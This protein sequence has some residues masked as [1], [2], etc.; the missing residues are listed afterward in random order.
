MA[1]YVT[2]KKLHR[3]TFLRGASALIA[4][5]YLDA[6]LP[7]IAESAPK[8]PI[9]SAFIY[10]PNGKKMDEWTP[11]S[12][13]A[14]FKFPHLLE[15]LSRY[16]EYIQILSGLTLDGARAHGDGA[17]DHARSAG[18]F[19]T[20]AHPVKTDVF[21]GVSIDQ[22]I[23]KKLGHSTNFPSLE[24]GCERGRRSGNCDSGYNCAYT[25]NIAWRSAT[26]PVPKETQPRALFERL[27]GDPKSALD[28]AAQ[29]DRQAKRKSI[30]DQALDD[31][32]RLKGKLGSGDRNKLDEYLESVRELEKRLSRKN[33]TQGAVKVPQGLYGGGDV[34]GYQARVR[35]MYDLMT[36]AFQTDQTRVMTYMLGNAGSNRSYPF[37][38]VAQGHHQ[39]SHHGNK[40]E[41]LDNLRKINRFQVEEFTR[42][43]G[44][45]KEIPDGT[46]SLLDH[47]MIVYGSGI[48][49]G[50]AHNHNNLPI[51]LAGRGGGKLKKGRHLIV[52]NRTPLANLYLAMLHKLGLKDRSFGDSTGIL[53]I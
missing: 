34:T 39:T 23:A 17:G 3:R 43:I 31:V 49:D 12:A 38:G 2:K 19:L 32:K 45:L 29:S 42:F 15:P 6:M 8:L 5:P 11:S 41:N 36:L 14:R 26:T 1:H 47:A 4:L 25:T 9:R 40:K 18:A 52:K 28:A 51:L 22:V 7:A 46:G 21:V 48:S 13:G 50:N 35:H 10:S 53:S 16:K 20:T 37:L 24:V 44:R 27:F 30:L 33:K